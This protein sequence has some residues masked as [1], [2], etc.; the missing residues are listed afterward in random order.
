MFTPEQTPKN[1]VLLR[2][3]KRDKSSLIHCTIFRASP[4]GKCVCTENHTVMQA[5]CRYGWIL[6]R[7]AACV[8][9]GICATIILPKPHSNRKNNIALIP[10]F[11]H[12]KGRAGDLIAARR[13][14]DANVYLSDDLRRVD[15][16]GRRRA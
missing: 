6:R 14:R 12:E 10:P 5:A 9:V 2:L 11:F 15:T 3:S 7:R 4:Q 16:S 8:T 1:R 13:N